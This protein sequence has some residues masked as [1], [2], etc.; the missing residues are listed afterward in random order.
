[1]KEYTYKGHKFEVSEPKDCVMTVSA[2]GDTV[3]ITIDAKG[4]YLVRGFRHKTMQEAVDY[5]CI[6]LQIKHPPPFCQHH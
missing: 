1:M 6:H 2:F 5:A 3:R 4:Y